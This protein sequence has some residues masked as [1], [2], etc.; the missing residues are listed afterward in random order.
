M[1]DLEQTLRFFANARFLRMLDTEGRK[2]LLAAAEALRFQ[3]GQVV[4]R[5]GEPGDALYIIVAGLAAISADNLVAEKQLGELGDGQFFG[6]MAV[7]TSQPRSA[8]VTAR[9]PLEVLRIPR[10]QVLAILK[11]YPKVKE[12]VAKIGVART[13]DTLEKMMKDD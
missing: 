4:V 9:G 1:P 2:R 8:T 13:E 10:D 12:V 7:I 11:D 5:E 6:E 3:D